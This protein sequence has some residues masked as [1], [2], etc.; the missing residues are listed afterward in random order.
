MSRRLHNRLIV[1]SLARR[2]MLLSLFYQLTDTTPIYEPVESRKRKGIV[3]TG[4]SGP[5]TRPMGFGL[6]LVLEIRR[7][8]LS[9]CL[10][11]AGEI[12][13][14]YFHALCNP[15]SVV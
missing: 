4:L 12:R 15:R 1:K 2:E 8:G 6:A 13:S 9:G 10:S 5:F 3:F 14:S 7:Q 11:V